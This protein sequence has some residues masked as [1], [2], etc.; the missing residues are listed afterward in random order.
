MIGVLGVGFAVS[1]IVSWP[2]LVPPLNLDAK[3][4]IIPSPST[5]EATQDGI[6]NEFS[7]IKRVK[8]D[9][10]GA[11]YGGSALVKGS[12]I[13]TVNRNV[14]RTHD[15]TGGSPVWRARWSRIETS[16]G[17]YDWSLLD[18]L[19]NAEHALGH[20]IVHTLTS[21]PPF[22][23]ARPDEKCG[24]EYG[25]C[26][27]PSDLTKWDSYCEAV[28]TRYAGRITHYEIWNEVNVRQFWTGSKKKMS[29]MVRRA[30]QT[31]KNIDPSAKIIA[32]AVTGLYKE[33]NLKFFVD[34]M[35]APDNAT[36]VLKDWVDIIN[37]HLHTPNLK[38]FDLIFAQIKNIREKMIDLKIND[39]PLWNTEYSCKDPFFKNMTPQLRKNAIQALLTIPAAHNSGGCDVSIVYGL[40]NANYGL[41]DADDVQTWNDMRRNLLNGDVTSIDWIRDFGVS[42]VIG[43]KEYLWDLRRQ[44]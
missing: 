2:K 33:S 16:P 26:A 44:S 19:V 31:I 6:T 30:S 7:G 43:G 41:V 9:Y 28:A 13:G 38:R 25:V 10:F 23:S 1:L 39:M 29:E 36:G 21:C 27:P 18:D 12:K 11:H 35:N 20:S 8:E 24:T 42:A 14:V 34:L 15:Y 37:V 40:D 17:T 4:S 22:Y 32:P 5:P 3:K